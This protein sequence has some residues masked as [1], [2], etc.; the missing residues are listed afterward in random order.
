M[1]Q[2]AAHASVPEVRCTVRRACCAPVGRRSLGCLPEAVRGLIAVR[3]SHFPATSGPSGTRR[4]C[5]SRCTTPAHGGSSASRAQGVLPAVRPGRLRSRSADAGGPVA[6]AAI[7][8]S[9]REGARTAPRAA[10]TPAWSPRSSRAAKSRRIDGQGSPATGRRECTCRM[11]S[12]LAGC[13]GESTRR[14]GIQTT[15]RHREALPRAPADELRR[16]SSRARQAG[17]CRVRQRRG[18]FSKRCGRAER[19]TLRRRRRRT[20][21]ALSLH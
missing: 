3:R 16:S 20:G 13:S 10:A 18:P 12:R 19:S 5:P 2:K 9:I 17:M 1:Q 15:R 4:R 6:Q 21:I 14:A 7:A 8:P 11:S